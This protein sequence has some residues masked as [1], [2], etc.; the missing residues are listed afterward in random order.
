MAAAKEVI[1]REACGGVIKGRFMSWATCILDV[2]GNCMPK[3]KTLHP[4]HDERGKWGGPASAREKRNAPPPPKPPPSPLAG[5]GD[6]NAPPAELA[7]AEDAE[8]GPTSSVSA[9]WL[10]AASSSAGSTGPSPLYAIMGKLSEMTTAMPHMSTVMA[11]NTDLE[12]M[13]T[14][15]DL[16]KLND[17]ML[18]HT[19][20]AT[21]EAA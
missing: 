16:C 7:T 14:K 8:T 12:N 21:T 2:C 4:E 5:E 18:M 15:S 11:T 13:D 6:R 17:A 19:C 1:Q 20:L 10:A 3:R 9:D